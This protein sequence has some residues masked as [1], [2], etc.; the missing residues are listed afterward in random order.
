MRKVYECDLHGH[1]NRSDG[2][3][4]PREYIDHA[5][6]RGLKVVAI[7]DH[8][9]IPPDKVETEMGCEDILKY[10]R[11][12]NIHLMKGIEISTETKIDDVHL[13]CFGCD[14]SLDYFKELDEFTIQSKKGSYK[15]LVLALQELG[16]AVSWDEVLDNNANPVPEDKVQK[17]MIFELMARKG[18]VESWKDAKLF[19]K[20]SPKLHIKREKPKAVEVIGQIHKMGG[21]V[22]LAHPYLIK[23]SVEYGGNVISR[24][25]FIEV[26]IEHGL[27]GIE[28][29][30][31]YDKTS[32]DGKM[33]PE[34]IEQEVLKK[35]E[36]RDL[37]MSGGSDYHGD[38][39]KGIKNPRDIGER[40]ISYAQF[41]SYDKLKVLIDIYTFVI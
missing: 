22:I 21:I 41:C 18:Y 36:G 33:T 11:R 4:T 12:K 26:L 34:E 3:D 24:E 25:E 23:E 6:S 9:V 5:A 2:N 19:V 13:V 30:Y 16:M 40:G 27:D 20:N 35:Y 15:K 29:S 10:A 7:T 31:S 17:K 14:W 8:D 32:Y 37:I 39:K 1:T 28:A 38:K